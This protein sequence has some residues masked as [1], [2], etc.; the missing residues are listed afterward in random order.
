M[1]SAKQKI[2]FVLIAVVFVRWP[3]G[4]LGDHVQCRFLPRASEVA[5]IDLATLRQKTECSREIQLAE[6]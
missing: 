2:L 1:Q 4:V 6:K 3:D 5:A